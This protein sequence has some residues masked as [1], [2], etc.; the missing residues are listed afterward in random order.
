MLNVLDPH[1]PL[2]VHSY[3]PID[4]NPS[5]ASAFDVRNVRREAFYLSC[6]LF[7]CRCTN[8]Y[9]HA[10]AATATPA[11]SAAL[12]DAQTRLKTL[13]TFV[14]TDFVDE[15]FAFASGDAVC[16]HETL[17]PL[18][19][20]V[21]AVVS[22]GNMNLRHIHTM[23]TP[24]SDRVGTTAFGFAASEVYDCLERLVLYCIKSFSAS[25]VLQSSIRCVR[26]AIDKGIV[27]E[28]LT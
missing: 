27:C 25:A 21:R 7:V 9:E 4:A 11:S 13:R 14:L 16:L 18:A 23:T 3:Y 1:G 17:V 8:A 2:G 15:S 28:D 24:D 12:S 26:A 6:G 5:S 20:F 19:Q 10:R 22:H